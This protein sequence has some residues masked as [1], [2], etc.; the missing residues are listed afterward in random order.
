LVLAQPDRLLR[1]VPVGEEVHK[2]K[3]RL[4]DM[5][6]RSIVMRVT[7]PESVDWKVKTALAADRLF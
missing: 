7:H 2:D 1:P 6:T 5:G 4:V 3:I